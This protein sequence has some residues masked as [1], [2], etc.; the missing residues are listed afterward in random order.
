VTRSIVYMPLSDVVPAEINPKAHDLDLIRDSL[1]RFE[2]VEPIILDERT[3]R[4]I[5]GHGRLETLQLER[6]VSAPAPDGLRVEHGV[7]LVPVV[8]GWASKDDNEAAGY[9]V[10]ANRITEVGGWKEDQLLD[11]LKGMD[12][13]GVGF[14][15]DDVDD[16]MAKLQEVAL[17]DPAAV[18]SSLRNQQIRMMV[19]YYPLDDYWKVTEAAGA[20]RARY[21][22]ESN[23]ELFQEMLVRWDRNNPNEQG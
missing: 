21:G 17:N 4:L 11:L 22:V 7:W 18:P 19:L 15:A 5:S 12:F 13:T 1:K 6:A 10:A 20:A 9:L 14:G 2:Y 16:L 8:R 23:A 3:G